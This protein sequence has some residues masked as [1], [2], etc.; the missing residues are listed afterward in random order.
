MRSYVMAFELCDRVL[1]SVFRFVDY[2]FLII[3]VNWFGIIM[4]MNALTR[5][6]LSHSFVRRIAYGMYIWYKPIK[7]G[8]FG[9]WCVLRPAFFLAVVT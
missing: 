2:F 7:K 3:I 8:R 9:C 1:R 4:R 5:L 6:E